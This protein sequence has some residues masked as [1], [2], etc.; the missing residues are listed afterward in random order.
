MFNRVKPNQESSKRIGRNRSSGHFWHLVVEWI[1]CLCGKERREELEIVPDP[2]LA[3]HFTKSV[4]ND[5]LSHSS[6]VFNYF[7]VLLG[8]FLG[9][10]WDFLGILCYYNGGY[11]MTLRD[12]KISSCGDFDLVFE[13]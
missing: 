2:F 9:F 4:R 6:G 1:P 13:K 7:K 10:S 8:I 11:K 3:N 12:A 5:T